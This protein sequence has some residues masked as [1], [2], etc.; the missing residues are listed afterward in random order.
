MSSTVK[1]KRSAGSNPPSSLNTGELAVTFGQ[2]LEN[3]LGDRLFIGAPGAGNN[4]SHNAGAPIVI[5]GKYF[6]DMMDHNRGVLTANSAILTDTNSKIDNLKVDNIDLDGNTISTTNSNGNLDLNPNGTGRVSIANTWT[7]PRDLGTMNYVLTTDGAG[8]SSWASPVTSL[9]VSADSGLDTQIDLLTETLDIE[10]N[11][12]IS[13]ASSPSSNKITVSVA[14]ATSSVLGVASFSTD[15][16]T[17]T[18]G[19]V[20]IKSAGISNSQLANSSVTF[21][22]TEVSL[23]SS[24]TTITG[25]TQL[26]VNLIN[27]GNYAMP[28]SDGSAG[29]ALVTDGAGQISFATVSTALNIAADTG[30][31]D[32]VQ[33]L[34]DTLTFTGTDPVQTSVSDNTI[35]I[36]VDDATGS[37]KG[38]ASFDTSGF[39]LTSGN[40]T[41]KANVVQGVTT[42]SGSMIPTS[43][44]FDILGGEGI[45]V[46]H[47][48]TTI[49]ISG[50]DATSSNKGIAN[51][52]ASY[53]T[54]TGGDVSINDA[55]TSAKGIANFD[56]N[57]FT[58]TNG[59]VSA[60]SITLGTTV[61][62]L[63]SSDLTLGGLQQLDVDHIRIDGNEI[64]TTDTDGNLSLHPNGTGTVDVN[65]ARITSLGTPTQA[66]DAATKE[67]VDAARSG[68]DVKHS[69]KAATTGPITLANT[70]VIDG[71]SLVVGDRV[72]VKDQTDPVE[73][74][75]YLVANGA[76]TRATDFDEPSEV[77]AGVFFF[78]EEGLIN[79]DH[80]FVITSNNPLTVGTSALIFTQFSG[81]GQI[82]AGDAL[83]KTGNRLD[84]VVVSD[85]G[86]EISADA[87]QLKSSLAG[88]GL[89]YSAGVLAVGGTS[90]RI[91]VSSD[92]IDIDSNYIG[93]STITTL[94]TIGTG[95][96][97]GT[98]IATPYGGTGQSSYNPYDLLIGNVASSLSK[99]AVGTI[100]QILQVVDNGAGGAQLAYGSIDCGTF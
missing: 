51:F 93:Q 28:T 20:T 31:S 70:Q 59:T 11:G 7:L 5:G 21:G 64:S 42:D 30:S 100:G 81:G 50:E 99:L 48:G 6:T 86:I 45:D 47:T 52:S 16:F 2:G 29:Q 92:S 1:I 72:L 98:V 46:T 34:T 37:N 49:T 9:T 75:V 79:G 97:Q 85:G 36:S 54:V 25:V 90:N 67:Y 61:L 77:T 62:D 8:T 13:T 88:D 94:G 26:D 83:T 14:T 91:S 84:V 27:I 18:S 19:D 10:G 33:L 96:W 3:N 68:L 80:G 82:T 15:S 57:N 95:I 22:T 60:K 76:W 43:N 35:T 58:V 74:G 23:G 38:I 44:G 89:T 56:T 78:V 32:T 17:V 39:D 87:L 4:L 55:T 12:A 24:S 65:N 73:N 66:T 71:I 53:F 40:V 41:L 63:G 69:V